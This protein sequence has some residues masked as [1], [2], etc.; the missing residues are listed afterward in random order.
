MNSTLNLNDIIEWDIPNWS[1][2]LDYWPKFTIQ[3]ASSINA[4]ELGSRNGGLS[5]WAAL[6]GMKILCTDIERPTNRAIEKHRS[7]GVS[8]RIKY[9][10]LNA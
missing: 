6:N 1:V 10:A 5:L 7:Y 9:K 3:N 8:D 2:A 4:L